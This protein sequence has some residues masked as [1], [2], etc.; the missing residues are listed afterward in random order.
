[1]V[2]EVVVR[3][4]REEGSCEVQT[5]DAAL[6]DAVRRHLHKAVVA[7]HL[8]HFGKQ[9]IERNRIGRGMRR[10]HYATVDT[11][12][13]RREQ[14]HTVAQRAKHLVEQRYGR[15]LAVGTGDTD[16]LQLLR[17]SVVEVRRHRAHHGGRIL[18][19]HVADTLAQLLGQLLA[20]NRHCALLNRTRDVG[21]TIG[22]RSHYGKEHRSLG[23]AARVESQ[24]AN[25]GSLRAN[26]ASVDAFDYIFYSFHSLSDVVVISKPIAHSRHA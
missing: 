16:Q 4:V 17:G 18:N 23:Y 14:T 8:N 13:D 1:M 12:L 10:G 2:V 9:C 3:D 21:V 11:I 6:H 26:H 7:T 22:R 24:R 5:T 19:H 15:G 25:L 20:D